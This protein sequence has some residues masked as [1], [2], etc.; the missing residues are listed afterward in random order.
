MAW[1]DLRSE[2]AEM[3]GELEQEQVFRAEQFL[4]R[5]KQRFLERRRTLLPRRG[6]MTPRE[7]N[8]RAQ[9]RSRQLTT[10][11]RPMRATFSAAFQITGV[12]VVVTTCACGA[13][14]EQ[15]E[16]SRRRLHFGACAVKRAAS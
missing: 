13:R 5:R 9:E 3:F 10:L 16:G 7:R 6:P 1:L 8:A 14:V 2:L 12:K 11:L 4:E 15:R